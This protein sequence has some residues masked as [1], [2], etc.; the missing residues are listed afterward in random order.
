MGEKINDCKVNGETCLFGIHLKLQKRNFGLFF[1]IVIRSVI[2]KFKWTD[3][4]TAKKKISENNTQINE[5]KRT[6]PNIRQNKRKIMKIKR[7]NW[8]WT[9][10]R[11]NG[12]AS[13]HNTFN[14]YC[15][16]RWLFFLFLFNSFPE[17]ESH[18]KKNQNNRVFRVKL[19]KQFSNKRWARQKNNFVST[20]AM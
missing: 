10:L 12:Y 13:S 1:F 14:V 8:T 5:F 17:P 18:N 6:Q 3:W 19:L 2:W 11:D 9:M 7:N 4:I 15:R 20:T 16:F